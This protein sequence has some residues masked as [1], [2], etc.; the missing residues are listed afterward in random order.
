MCWY[1]KSKTI[2][3]K[4][5]EEDILVV[6]GLNRKN[7]EEFYSP[8]FRFYWKKGVVY[9]SILSGP[10]AD[11]SKETFSISE[12]FHS[13]T[14]LIYVDDYMD[15]IPFTKMINEFGRTVLCRKYDIVNAVIPKGALYYV[16]EE[17]DYVSNQLKIV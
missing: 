6:K 17:G 16:N 14:K 4:V 13:C 8:I 2:R 9:H 5:A 7:D 11:I 12:G 10:K 1:T 3:V 15:G